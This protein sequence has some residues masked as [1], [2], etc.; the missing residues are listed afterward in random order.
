MDITPM[1]K[2]P[3]FRRLWIGYTISQ[4]GSQLTVVA[5]AYEIYRINTFV[6]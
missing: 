1:R 4:L 2:Y 6:S 5:V 3:Q